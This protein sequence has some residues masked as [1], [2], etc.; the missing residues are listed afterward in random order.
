[1]TA[2]TQLDLGDRLDLLHSLEAKLKRRICGQT[3][4]LDRLAAAVR[5][6]ET[7]SVPL[8]AR[9]RCFIF[10]GPTGVGKTQTAT[11]LADLVFGPGCLHRF[12]CGELQTKES[13]AS[14]LGNRT[15]DRGRFGDAFSVVS[16]GIWLFDELEKAVPE[17]LLLL[18]AMTDAARLTLANGETLDLS[19]LYLI[20][21]TNLGSAE[22]LGRHHLPFTSIEKHVVGRIRRHFRPEL[23]A[24]FLRPM[25]FRPLEPDTRFP[26]AALHLGMFLIWHAEQGCRVQAGRDVV[27]FLLRVGYTSQL[28]ARPLVD[29]IH[30]YVGDAIARCRMTGGSGS[31]RLVVLQDRLEVLP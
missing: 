13:V 24:R 27:E 15:G 6:R 8:L 18:L 9:E 31:G 23:L 4:V 11:S 17:F 30:E 22:I 1:M 3:E 21:T 28:G 29:A 2:A 12:D 10:A 19:R 20:V 7:G 14:L 16:R 5:R 26:I 25:V